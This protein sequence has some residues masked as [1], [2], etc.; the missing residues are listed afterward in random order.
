MGRIVDLCGEI[1]AA[2]E[3][4]AEGL[5]LP[6]DVWDRLRADWDDEDIEDALGLV[7]DSLM[8]AELVES[9]DTLSGRLIEILGTF[10]EPEA[11]AKLVASAG[12]VRFEAIAQLA[13]RVGRLE[14]VL[15][16]YREGAPPDRRGFDALQK[17]LADHGIEEDLTE[18][19]A[20][21]AAAATAAAEAE[22]QEDED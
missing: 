12:V 3:E 7:H 4:G 11:F 1:A 17:R 9:A 6:P 22:D 15:E 2:A 8:Q 16:V 20:E 19:R 21:A 14:E 18:A 13:R 5:V 10:G